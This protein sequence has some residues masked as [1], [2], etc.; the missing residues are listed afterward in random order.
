MDEN[1]IRPPHFHRESATTVLAEDFK[2]PGN[3]AT[4]QLTHPDAIPI[5]F[6]V[7]AS[8]RHSAVPHDLPNEHSVAMDVLV[9]DR[10]MALE[11]HSGGW[12]RR[13]G[14]EGHHRLE[15]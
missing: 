12:V 9:R 10:G 14:E 8:L 1:K 13:R 5:S 15:N 4:K 3:A 11:A 6:V 7:A 2:R